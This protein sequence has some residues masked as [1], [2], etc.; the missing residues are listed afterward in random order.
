MIV[1][2]F[3]R[4]SASRIRP[5]ALIIRLASFYVS[6]LKLRQQLGCRKSSLPSQTLYL[7]IRLQLKCQQA[8]ELTFSCNCK[9]PKCSG[10][11]RCTKNNVKCSAHCH[12][13]EFDRGNLSSLAFR[14]C[15]GTSGY[16]GVGP[17]R[18]CRA[19]STGRKR[20]ATSTITK[21][22]C[23]PMRTRNRQP[24]AA[25]NSESLESIKS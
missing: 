17:R 22:L 20:G 11:C 16:C 1:V 19:S 21:A 14:D 9:P 15:I 24:Q 4:A 2:S 7:C 6:R 13:S 8:L 10:R 3:H 5:L 23:V 12:S 18:S 25:S